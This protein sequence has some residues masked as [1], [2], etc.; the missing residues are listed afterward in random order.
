MAWIVARTPVL[1]S[2][3]EDA[4]LGPGIRRNEAGETDPVAED[5]LIELVV[6]SAF[7]PLDLELQR[8]DSALRVWTTRRKNV[9][10]EL[11]FTGDRGTQGKQPVRAT[12]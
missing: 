4:E 12:Q 1:D 10:T 8:T 11:G 3:E 5:D 7:A 2:W 6:D 9:G